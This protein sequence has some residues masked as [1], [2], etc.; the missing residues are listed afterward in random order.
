MAAAALAQWF[1]TSDRQALKHAIENEES[2]IE[3]AQRMIQQG[4]RNE[5]E[6]DLIPLPKMD[7]GAAHLAAAMRYQER[8]IAEGLCSV[9]PEPLARNSVRYCEKHL[10]AARLR[11]KPK[12]AK[13]S[14]PGSIGWLH[15]EGFESQQGRQPGTL[16][17]LAITRKKKSGALLA[18]LGMPSESA[19]TALEAAKEALLERMPRSEK[20]AITRW[21]LFDKA[22][23]PNALKRTATKALRQLLSAGQIQHNGKGIKGDP[24]LYWKVEKV[25][26]DGA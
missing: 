9:C 12:N 8:N 14:P 11:K 4:Q 7:P 3:W 21:E 13:G 26:G 22:S 24:F 10:T 15:G 17:S 6:D 5:A 18:Q 25:F 1:R 19:A 16:Q 2:P 20:D 23:L